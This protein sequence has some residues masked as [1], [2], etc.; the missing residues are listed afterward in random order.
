[1]IPNPFGIYPP[2]KGTRRPISRGSLR[3]LYTRAGGECERCGCSLR[4]L[5]GHIHHK[6]RKKNDNRLPNL[7]LLCP[8]CHSRVHANDKP[9][10]P[11]RPPNPFTI[12]LPSQKFKLGL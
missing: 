4:G 5:K 3:D 1:M 6:N 7:R 11:R 2:R 12:K 9:R 10:K 8:T